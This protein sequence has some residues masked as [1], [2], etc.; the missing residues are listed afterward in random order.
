MNPAN[1]VDLEAQRRDCI[2]SSI[3]SEDDSNHTDT[4]PVTPPTYV[5]PE[6]AATGS[7]PLSEFLS[8]CA[9]P[10]QPRTSKSVR[11]NTSGTCSNPSDPSQLQQQPP[12]EPM[13]ITDEQRAKWRRGNQKA[14]I[15]IV[16]FV[17]VVV[18]IIAGL[19]ISSK[20]GKN[21]KEDVG[22]DSVS[23]C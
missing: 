4:D 7:R 20:G 17:L 9:Y 16:F 21:C 11:K 18:G 15:G 14:V 6:P 13:K 2:A 3:G 10:L 1:G 5:H 12:R 8:I 23:R 22:K 19:L